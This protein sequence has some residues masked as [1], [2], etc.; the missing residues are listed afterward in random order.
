MWLE[1]LCQRKIPVKP[2]GIETANFRFV[3]HCLNQ[4]RQ[5]VPPKQDVWESEMYGRYV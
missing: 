1:G 2:S 4:L 5:N 3:T